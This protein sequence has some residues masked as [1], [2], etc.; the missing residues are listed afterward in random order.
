MPVCY[1]SALTFIQWRRDGRN[2]RAGFQSAVTCIF[3]SITIWL[4]QETRVYGFARALSMKCLASRLGVRLVSTALVLSYGLWAFVSTAAFD[5]A[6]TRQKKQKPDM[7]Q[8]DQ[9]HIC[10]LL[11]DKTSPPSHLSIWSADT[12]LWN[13]WW[14]SWSLISVIFRIHCSG[15]SLG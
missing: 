3:F 7:K 13:L 5:A 11:T 14:C 9:S 4:N 12:N 8:W 2:S 6:N 15:T 1:I 10:F